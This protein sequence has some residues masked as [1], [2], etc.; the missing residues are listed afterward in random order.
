[1]AFDL[2][3]IG[4][5]FISD[6]RRDAIMG[7]GKERSGWTR[8]LGKADSIRAIDRMIHYFGERRCPREAERATAVL[9]VGVVAAH[10]AVRVRI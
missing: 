8:W 3:D 9:R 1:V 6:T 2:L 5:R 4:Q 10:V 7:N